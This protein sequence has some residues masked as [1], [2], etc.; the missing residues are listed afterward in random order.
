MPRHPKDRLSRCWRRLILIHGQKEGPPQKGWAQH[1]CWRRRTLPPG[2]P[3]STI[4][5]AELNDRVRDGNGCILCAKTTSDIKRDPATGL[6]QA[7]GREKK[8][9]TLVAS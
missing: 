4:R 2:H 7:K 6:D 1:V 9:Q 8:Q 3:G 5:A